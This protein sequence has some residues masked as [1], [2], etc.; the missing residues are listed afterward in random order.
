MLAMFILPRAKDL[1]VES[2]NGTVHFNK[3]EEDVAQNQ[4]LSQKIFSI[5]RSITT[6][7]GVYFG[8]ILRFMEKSQN[9]AEKIG[10]SILWGMAAAFGG[11]FLALCWYWRAF[12]SSELWFDADYTLFDYFRRFSSGLFHQLAHL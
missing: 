2:K 9:L 8:M 5:A 6:M 7:I 3:L 10:A 4:T 12:S 1:Q 11:L